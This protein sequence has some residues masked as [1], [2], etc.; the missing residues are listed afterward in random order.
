MECT[1]C[2]EPICEASTTGHVRCGHWF[3]F[4]CL[5]LWSQ[6]SSSCPICRQQFDEVA[7][8]A[9]SE[10]QTSSTASS[11][12][13]FGPVI[14]RIPCV[15]RPVPLMPVPP[16]E[17]MRLYE[18]VF[19]QD[20]A[21]MEDVECEICGQS[22]CVCGNQDEA[23]SEGFA[24]PSNRRRG[25]NRSPGR[26]RASNLLGRLGRRQTTQSTQSGHLVFDTRR[27]RTT[28]A[29]GARGLTLSSDNYFLNDDDDDDD[30]I[31]ETRN[32]A[33]ASRASVEERAWRFL[34]EYRREERQPSTGRRRSSLFNVFNADN[35]DE[36]RPPTSDETPRTSAAPGSHH[37]SVATS[38]SS[39][40]GSSVFSAFSTRSSASSSRLSL[41]SQPCP[42]RQSSAPMLS[43]PVTFRRPTPL[44]FRNPL[45]ANSTSNPTHD[46]TAESEVPSP[47]SGS[48]RNSPPA[49][50]QPQPQP[51]QPKSGSVSPATDALS[52]IQV[53]SPSETATG[54]STGE[55]Q[56]PLDQNSAA[57]NSSDSVSSSGHSL[58]Y[59]K[60]MEIRKIVKARLHRYY[61]DFISKEQFTEINMSVCDRVYSYIKGS[62]SREPFTATQAE[63]WT[64]VVHHLV[65]ADLVAR[66]LLG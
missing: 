61:P 45:A 13:T 31:E 39:A 55:S 8:R 63:K 51:Q 26:T 25:P 46:N 22:P 42:P 50:D 59:E 19:Q 15:Q 20:D 40:S 29:A 53:N 27:R 6:R 41:A 33:R 47:R 62:E 60:K 7:E 17:A 54:L 30:N 64:K 12:P 58:S 36:S 3:H 34:D 5:H 4:E 35:E 10:L 9:I 65:S 23:S 32:L 43:A 56:T 52:H 21:E 24:H 66:D 18:F 37:P 1:I 2:L 49:E 11:I 14:K 28:T 48:P 57:Q 38:I 16:E 44:P